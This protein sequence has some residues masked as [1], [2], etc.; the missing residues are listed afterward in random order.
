MIGRM[1][2]EAGLLVLAMGASA[3]GGDDG[4]ARG[5][6]DADTAGQGSDGGA[7]VDPE[8][9]IRGRF[10]P[11]MG[12]D[13]SFASTAA[14]DVHAFSGVQVASCSSTAAGGYALGVT[15][16]D[17]IAAGVYGAP[18]LAMGPY[19]TIGWPQADGSGVH[20]TAAAQGSLT[21]TEVGTA[22]GQVVAGTAR[23]ALMPEAADLDDLYQAIEDV[24]FR[25]VVP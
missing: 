16:P 13:E 11:V 12:D 6:S 24:A 1:G 17:D 25:C 18:D 2:V 8:N 20:G 21:F 4:D 5:S 22:S 9:F 19:L 3:C 15:F 23:A 10:V 14:Y 7:V